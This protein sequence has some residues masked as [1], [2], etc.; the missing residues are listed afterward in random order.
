LELEGLFI[1]TKRKMVLV[2]PIIPSKKSSSLILIFLLAHQLPT[3][4]S[5]SPFISPVRSLEASLAASAAQTTVVVVQSFR[6]RSDDV[7][8]DDDIDIEDCVVIL[9]RTSPIIGRELM[10]NLTRSTATTATVVDDTTPHNN[11]KPHP[12]SDDNNN[13]NDYLMLIYH[14]VV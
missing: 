11:T 6:D 7:D 5:S 9:S 8:V 1:E 10:F 12:L 3:L 4:I 2:P 13:D 14:A